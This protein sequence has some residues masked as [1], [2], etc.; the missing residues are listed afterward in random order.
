MFVDLFHFT[1]FLCVCVNACVHVCTPCACSVHR[2]Q[3]RALD[4]S[5]T[6]IQ[7]VV[8]HQVESNPGPGGEQVL[9]TSEPSP[10][11]LAGL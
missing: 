6:G 7:M 5:G 1:Y 10:A 2:S 4:P 11:L 8:S 9:L 3:K